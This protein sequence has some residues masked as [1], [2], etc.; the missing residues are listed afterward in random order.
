MFHWT[1]ARI[2][3][4]V[5]LCVLALLIQ[6][7]AELRTE[8]TWRNLHHHLEGLKAI[9]YRQSGKTI[10][11]RNRISPEL[12]EILTKLSVPTPDKVLRIEG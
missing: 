6:R 8:D 3:A 7:A 12:K 2:E 1:P 10:V 5:K 9:R 4:H 11:Q